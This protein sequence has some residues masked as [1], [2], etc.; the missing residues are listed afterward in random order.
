[1]KHLIFSDLHEDHEAL[2]CMLDAAEQMGGYDDIWFLGDALGKRDESSKGSPIECL[3]FLQQ[4]VKICVIGNWEGW[5]R[6]PEKDDDPS[7]F[8]YKWA[9]LLKS[10][11][12]Q[13]P[14]ELM[15]FVYG[16]DWKLLPNSSVTIT[17]GCTHQEYD[18]DYLRAA[19]WETYIE[20]GDLALVEKI[21]SRP[22]LLTTPHLIV[23]HTHNPGY[24]HFNGNY[25]EWKGLTPQGA[26][27][28]IE[29]DSFKGRYLWNPGSASD[30]RGSFPLP[31]A[32][33]LD[34]DARTFCFLAFHN[35]RRHM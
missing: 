6:Q 1:M 28:W 7:S 31:T 27:Q 18:A 14:P 22:D 5:L 34:T 21:Y 24:H 35:A 9:P 17:H 20:A 8:Q 33:M 3:Q 4:Y 23:G 15:E 13:L 2:L 16:W 32:L 26:N 25:P 19:P 12:E 29:M 30:N 11:R 10:L